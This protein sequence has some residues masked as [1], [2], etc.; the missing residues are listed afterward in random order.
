M[1]VPL[2]FHDPLTYNGTLIFYVP[3]TYNGILTF[4][5]LLTYYYSISEHYETGKP[6]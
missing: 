5:V 4:Y 1:T 6:A 3:L 2:I